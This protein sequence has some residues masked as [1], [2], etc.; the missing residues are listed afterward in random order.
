[1]QESAQGAP[2]AIR[3]L[4]EQQR[5]ELDWRDGHQSVYEGHRTGYYTW[6]LLRQRCSCNECMSGPR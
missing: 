4:R 6:S 1:M 2:V 3:I 5:L